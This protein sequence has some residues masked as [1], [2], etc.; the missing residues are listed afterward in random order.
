MSLEEKIELVLPKLD[1][2]DGFNEILGTLENN[3]DDFEIKVNSD[4]LDNLK[5]RIRQFEIFLI[6]FEKNALMQE[7]YNKR[8]NVFKC[9]EYY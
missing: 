6:A 7:S 9:T 2:L 1:K 8:L 4:A 5:K 3:F